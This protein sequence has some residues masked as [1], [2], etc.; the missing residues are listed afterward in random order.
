VTS[1]ES[2]GELGFLRRLR[3]LLE[4]AGGELLVG[5]GQDDAAAWTEPG[6]AGSVT[7][8]TCDAM[9]E[10]V[11]F[12]LAWLSPFEVGWRAVALALGDL[13][14]KGARPAYGLVTVSA[15]RAWPVERLVEIYQGMA[16]AARET[17][18]RLVG[19]DTTSSPGPAFISVTALGRATAPV[20]PRSAAQP[21]WTVAVTGALGAAA[22][23]LEAARAGRPLRPE[24]EVALRRPL[25]RLAEGRLLADAGLAVGDISDG[26]LREMDKFAEASGAGCELTL[27]TVPVAAGSTPQQ[28]LASGEE[29]ELV[30]CGP[31]PA[32][33]E[34]AAQ[35]DCG[36]TQV[37][38]LTETPEV[39]VL[40]AGGAEV[41][42][43]QRG[44]DHFA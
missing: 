32:I 44:Y 13:A 26:L 37:G 36:L 27:G 38:R 35:L 11:H 24:W 39:R 17:G 25:P 33:R 1:L 23:A 15:P 2:N 8:A 30:C 31:E 4:Q 40:D 5:P 12:D 20:V 29:V 7:V 42:V 3:P 22:A 43:T 9:V 6:P 21:G 19:G 34:L 41:R 28:A 18:L 10:G 14:A 16:A